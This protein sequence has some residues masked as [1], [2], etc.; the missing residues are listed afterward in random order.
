MLI[1]INDPYDNKLWALGSPTKHQQAKLS[2]RT[3]NYSPRAQATAKAFV[4]AAWLGGLFVFVAIVDD[5]LR[6]SGTV[7]VMLVVA[8]MASLLAWKVFQPERAR[9]HIASLV[10]DGKVF[11]WGT[12][13]YWLFV[14]TSNRRDMTEHKAAI[15]AQLLNFSSLARL[16][17]MRDGRGETDDHWFLRTGFAE[18]WSS[19]KRLHISQLAAVDRDLEMILDRVEWEIHNQLTADLARQSKQNEL[20]RQTLERRSELYRPIGAPVQ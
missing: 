20:V 7:V 8:L 15:D 3:E 4:V 16:A 1:T 11:L 6:E 18:E 17:A 10:T 12:P 2:R 13:A 19:L 9:R 14:N 5:P